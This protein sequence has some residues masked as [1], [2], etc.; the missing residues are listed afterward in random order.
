ML[1][2]SLG[3]GSPCPKINKA[4]IHHSPIPQDLRS[5]WLGVESLTTLEKG[6]FKMPID[7]YIR[8]PFVLIALSTAPSRYSTNSSV[9]SKA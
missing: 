8:V 9:T 6:E 2:I 7:A 1:Q 5:R 3:K 4:K